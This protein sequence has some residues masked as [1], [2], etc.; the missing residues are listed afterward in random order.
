LGGD[1]TDW[2]QKAEILKFEQGMSYTEVTNAIRQEYFPGMEWAKAREK[3]RGH[4]RRCGRYHEQDETSLSVDTAQY[5]VVVEYRKDGSI[6]YD[7]L[8]EVYDDKELTPGDMLKYHGLDVTAWDIVSYKNNY[9]HS[10][11]KGG[12]RLLMCQSK[13]VVKPKHKAISFEEIEKQYKALDRKYVTP[14]I[15]QTKVGHLMA[16][17]N[18]ADIHFGKLCWVGDTGNNF[19]Y[20]IA[21]EMFRQIISDIYNELKNKELEYILFVWTND[22]FNSDTIDKTTTGGT[23]QDTD[24]RWQKLFAV[25]TEALVE[26]T[27]MLSQIA[28]VKTLYT[29]S[30]HDEVTAYHALCYL[31]A[32]FRRDPNIEID[33][34]PIARKYHL[35]GNTLIGFAHGDDAKPAKLAGIMPVEAPELWG[36]SKYREYHTAHLHSEHAIEEINGVITRR[37]S[38]PTATDTWHY[39]NGFVGAVRKAQT[40]IYDKEKGLVATYNTVV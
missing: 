18:V 23:P 31:N 16:E 9:W 38:S 14:K 10:Q 5:N 27:D 20:K 19:D 40:F 3:I 11:M 26:A 7:R 1:G 4:I 22:F 25:G 15:K 30:N 33:T 8:I 34:N 6:I 21:K 37:I 32:W 12:R 17:V 35:Y 13:I 24:I 28:P 36:K 2:K 29:A 39:K